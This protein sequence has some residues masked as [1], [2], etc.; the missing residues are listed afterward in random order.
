MHSIFLLLNALLLTASP[1]A[2][3]TLI[4]SPAAHATSSG[5]RAIRM[6]TEPPADS[7]PASASRDSPL[8]GFVSKETTDAFQA[9]KDADNAKREALRAKI[10]IA[11]PVSFIGSFL[12][13]LAIGE[14][15]VKGS[16]ADLG[17][18]TAGAP[19]V[20]EARAA[21][22]ARVEKVRLCMA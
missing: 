6:Q 9:K 1:V 18:P 3:Y 14:D 10:N 22:K 17:D 4:A 21:K 20:A 15:N 19:G 16:L 8:A 5:L 7:S 12:I 2:A 13:A 11:L